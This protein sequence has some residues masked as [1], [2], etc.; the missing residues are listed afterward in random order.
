[1]YKRQVFPVYD[2]GTQAHAMQLV[3]AHSDVPVPDVKFVEL[4]DGPLG[5][6]FIV[7]RRMEGRALADIPPYTFGGSFLDE[8]DASQRREFQRNFMSVQA[9]LHNI[10]LTDVDTSFIASPDGGDALGRQLDAQYEYF[11]WARAGRDFP[12]IDRGLAW[13]RDNMP[14]DPGPTVLNWGDAR[15]GNVLVDGVTPS[16]VLDWEM[17]DLGPAAVDVAWAIFLHSFFQHIAGVFGVPGFPDMFQHDD[18]LADY[19]AAG[20]AALPDLDWFIMFASVRF[21]IVSVRTSSR[22]AAYGNREMPDD[23]QDLIMHRSIF[24]QQ[25]DDRA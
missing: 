14:S 8:L 24:E 11:E 10:D 23:L 5:A 22:E 4:D 12:L 25:L 17:V 21:A 7:M 3:A 16:A 15:P 6:P 18:V 1:M 2:M 9:Q 13:L 20:G 19:E